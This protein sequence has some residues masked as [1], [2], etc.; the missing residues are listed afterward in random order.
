[1]NNSKPSPLSPKEI[2]AARAREL[3]RVPESARPSEDVL[4]V[5]EFQLAHEHYAVEARYV[6]E[7]HPFRELTPL[8]FTPP[9]ILGIVNVRGRILPVMDIKKFFDLPD[10][11]LT[12]L[13][14][15]I[16]LHHAEVELGLLADL[17][18]GVRLLPVEDLQPSLPTLTGVRAEYLKGVTRDRLIV[19]D[20]ARILSDPKIIVE[21]ELDT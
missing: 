15:I 3:A 20:A 1:M 11:G 16:F 19:L 18:V 6:R 2:L 14:R 10:G 5:L 4:E 13:H 21:D 12:D 8:P 9:F 7:V 17:S